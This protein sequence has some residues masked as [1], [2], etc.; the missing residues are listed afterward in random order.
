VGQEPNYITAR[1]KQNFLNTVSKGRICLALWRFGL[2][3]RPLTLYKLPRLVTRGT[4]L[5]LHPFSAILGRDSY[6]YSLPYRLF[7]LCTAVAQ[8]RHPKRKRKEHNASPLP[9]A[10][11]CPLASFI[12][13]FLLSV[14]QVEALAYISEQGR[15][16]AA[17]PDSYNSKKRD[18]L[19]LKLSPCFTQFS[20]LS[21]CGE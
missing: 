3:I 18:L 4:P 2:L 6:L 1:K 13:V 7:S 14:W 12:F 11:S 17:E 8:L 16:A 9:P 21:E 19:Y 10:I 20:L 5:F 15:K